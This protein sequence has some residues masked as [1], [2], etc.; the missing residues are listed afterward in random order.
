[1]KVITRKREDAWIV[2][3]QPDRINLR[4]PTKKVEKVGFRFPVISLVRLN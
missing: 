3:W 1:M 4:K 2:T